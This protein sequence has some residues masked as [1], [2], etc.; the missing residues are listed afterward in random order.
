[1]VKLQI[2]FYLKL[3]TELFLFYLFINQIHKLAVGI[4]TLN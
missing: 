3:K 2:L 1:M 4:T